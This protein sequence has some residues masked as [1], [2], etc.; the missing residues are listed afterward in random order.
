MQWDGESG[1]LVEVFELP[2]TVDPDLSRI[3]CEDPG[4]APFEIR[5]LDELP[6]GWPLDP[7]EI[8]CRGEDTFE[9]DP[10]GC[11]DGQADPARLCP[12]DEICVLYYYSAP[13]GEPLP[14]D[15]PCASE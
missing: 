6:E 4:G 11:F 8:E 12:T 9:W 13:Y 14:E 5:E 1:H 2:T 7:S 15:W 3:V 10:N